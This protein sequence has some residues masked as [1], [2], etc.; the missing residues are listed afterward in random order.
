MAQ[1]SW[2]DDQRK[3]AE[4]EAQ[5]ERVRQTFSHGLTNIKSTEWVQG[6]MYLEGAK[7]IEDLKA[8]C[9]SFDIVWKDEGDMVT[10]NVELANLK[11]ELNKIQSKIDKLE[12]G[13]LGKE[14]SNGT[15]FKIEKRFEAGGKGYQYAA[16]RASGLWYLTG[17]GA[18]SNRYYTWEELKTFIGKYSRVWAM[19]VR[20]ELV[21]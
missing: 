1:S 20:E 14:P 5:R 13:R 16:I 9:R 12:Y 2:I 7:T 3:K 18:T 21:D 19:T 15:V 4:L 8:V 10:K 6:L 11:A 17:T